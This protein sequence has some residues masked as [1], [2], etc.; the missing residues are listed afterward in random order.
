MVSLIDLHTPNFLLLAETLSLHNDGALTHTLR[1][2]GYTMYYQPINAPTPPDA[3]PEAR[4]SNHLTH[5]GDGCWI[6][7]RKYTS[8]A[9][10]VR[11]LR[12]PIYCPL[13]T[14]CVVEVT[15]HSGEKAAI[16]ARHL[17]QPIDDHEKALGRLPQGPPASPPRTRRES[18]GWLDKLNAE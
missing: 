13:A 8:W 3:L 17:P 14:T 6:T 10:H 2:R 7:Y 1:N 12:L 16:I 18:Q 5:S 9:T 15:L 11:H 4:F